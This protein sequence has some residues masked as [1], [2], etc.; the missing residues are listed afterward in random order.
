[1]KLLNID[2]RKALSSARRIV[3]KLGT[4]VLVGETG[5]PDFARIR[6]L[7]NEIAQLHHAGKEIVLV[8]SGA[9]AVGL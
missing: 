7:I 6:L 9:I 3:V 2:Q 5:E 4:R 8:S 1:M